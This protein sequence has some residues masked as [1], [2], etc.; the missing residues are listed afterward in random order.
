MNVRRG[1][2]S[3]IVNNLIADGAIFEGATGQAVRDRKPTFLY[4][5]S[6]RRAVVAA[7]IRAR[8]TFLML[9]DLRGNPT[10]GVV[11]GS[12]RYATPASWRRRCQDDRS[13]GQM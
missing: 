3:R 1:A 9:A 4:I 7:D 5:D 10:T 2:I 13:L 8:E 12:R 6:R 11:G